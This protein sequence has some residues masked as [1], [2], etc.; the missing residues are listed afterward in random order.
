MIGK[1]AKPA[2]P[3]VV[4]REFD[5][6]PTNPDGVEF[7]LTPAERSQAASFA[8]QLERRR[9]ELNRRDARMSQ[10]HVDAAIDAMLRGGGL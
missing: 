7:V 8:C 1:T 6:K 10:A 3:Y 2:D 9:R 4:H 5:P